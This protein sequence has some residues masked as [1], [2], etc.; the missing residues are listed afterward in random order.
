MATTRQT[1]TQT[2]WS[3]SAWDWILFWFTSTLHVGFPIINWILRYKPRWTPEQ[4]TDK[5]GQVV[6][7]TG[8]NSGTGYATAQAYYNAGARVIM[9]CRSAQRAEQAITEIQSGA[10]RDV[11]GT[12]Q[13]P[14][15]PPK[16]PGSLEF[17][18]MDLSDLHSVEAAAKTIL[19]REQRIDVFFANAGIMAV[20]PAE[21]KQG[22]ALQFG[23]NVLGHQRL[24]S[25]LLPLLQASSRANPGSPSRLIVSSSVAHALAPHRGGDDGGI[26]YDTLRGTGKLDRIAEYGESKWGSVALAR[27]VDAHYGPGT[28]DGEILSY[29]IHPGPVASN[30]GNHLG[31][32]A[33]L[34]INQAVLTAMQLT[35]DEGALNQ[36]WLADM[37]V[38]Q[39]RKL[40]GEYVACIQN[41]MP[42]RPDLSNPAAWEKLWNW[43]E[44]EG[45]LL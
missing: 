12:L 6:L 8:A 9:A 19:E 36:L 28:K 27:Y 16:T 31:A 2:A 30:L 17:L 24:I 39:A 18:S 7:I 41:P 25:R 32:V 11:T 3:A 20:P 13:V 42:A 1:T 34:R 35:P 23:T 45:K 43:C 10:R 22:Y 33:L 15:T 29:A 38:D 14:S 40:R 37:P 4:M 21:T 5:S 44:A 26:A